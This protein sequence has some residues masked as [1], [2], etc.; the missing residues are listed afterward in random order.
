MKTV[1]I[2][3][4][5][6]FIGRNLKEQLIGYRLL[7]PTHDMLNL[8]D[9]NAVCDY[10]KSKKPNVII[11]SV[12]KDT[13]SMQTLLR[14]FLNLIKYKPEKCRLL[15][16]GSGA[17]KNSTTQYGLAKKIIDDITQLLPN[18]FNLRLYG[19]YGKYE[20]E[21][22]RFLSV[23]CKSLLANKTITIWDNILFNYLYVNDLVKI[24][25]L[26]IENTPSRKSYDIC[27]PFTLYLSGWA[28]ALMRYAN[29][30]TTIIIQENSGKSYTASN[31]E[32]LKEFNVQFTPLDKSLTEL[33]N[34][35]KDNP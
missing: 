32:L 25:R 4:S 13:D 18:V 6:G 34:F 2:S 15:H 28:N 9:E 26:F 22:K 21:N 8:E 27:S 10:F 24:V 23:C 3:G 20:D 7:T 35:Y 16:F 14:M 11:H 29:K 19:V 30:K 33:Y 17:E 31:H 5:N 1:L 12:G